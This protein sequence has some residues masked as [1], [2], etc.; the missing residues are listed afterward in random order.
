MFVGLAYS[1]VPIIEG[2]VV[3]L[4]GAGLWQMDIVAAKGDT[5]L[6]ENKESKAE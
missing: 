3:V 6:T 1:F 5:N 2:T 4:K